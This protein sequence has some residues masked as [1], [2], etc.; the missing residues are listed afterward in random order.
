MPSPRVS[1]DLTRRLPV[2]Q[3]NVGL[4][5]RGKLRSDVALTV[6]AYCCLAPMRLVQVA[7]IDGR[8][9]SAETR[10]LD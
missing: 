5:P 7:C 4:L 10:R 2:I 6:S 1:S 9:G 3:R 8:Q